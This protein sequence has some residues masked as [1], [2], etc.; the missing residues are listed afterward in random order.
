MINV[1]I[2]IKKFW[3]CISGFD[4][5]SPIDYRCKSLSM[6]NLAELQSL[7]T[8]LKQNKLIYVF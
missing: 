1:I 8:S 4:W 6:E 3:A 7:L 5:A 2:K